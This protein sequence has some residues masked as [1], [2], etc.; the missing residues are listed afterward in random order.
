MQSDGEAGLSNSDTNSLHSNTFDLDNPDSPSPVVYDPVSP[1]A[2][3][4]PYPIYQH[5]RDYQPLYYI[6]EHDAWALS[7][8]TDVQEGL[9]DWETFSSAEGV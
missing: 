9:R 6:A 4:D 7:R 2:H 5:L 3:L 1:E 8:Y